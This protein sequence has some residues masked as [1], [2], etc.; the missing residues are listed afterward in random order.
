MDHD[1]EVTE[2][3]SWYN[4]WVE[5]GEMEEFLKRMS[6]DATA[7]GVVGKTVGGGYKL[8]NKYI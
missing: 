2:E 7:I 8:N 4:K 6:T 1:N 3:K 5:E